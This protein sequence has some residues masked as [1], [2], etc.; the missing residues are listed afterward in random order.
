[1]SDVASPKRSRAWCLTVNNYSEEEF[2]MLLHTECRYVILGREVGSEGTPHIQ[3]YLYFDL[4][5]SFRQ[6][7]LLCPRAHFEIAKGSPDDNYVYCSKDHAYEERGSIPLSPSKKAKKGGDG[8]AERI[9]AAFASAAMGQLDQIPGDLRVRYYRTFKDIKKDHMPSVADADDLTGVWITGPAGCGKSRF[10]RSNYKDPYLK[11]CNKWWDGYQDEENVIIDDFDKTHSVL[12][13]H[14][15]I[16]GDRYSF[17]GETKGGAIQ[18]RPKKIVIT[19]Q[20]KIEDIW[21]DKETQDALNRRFE[22]LDFA[23]D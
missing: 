14:L 11:M 8:N 7:K 18:I 17:I 19:S 16:W 3:G 22:V 10:A 2:Q 20:Y 5:K 21:D 1:M 6:V 9:A 15:K 4:F 12:G 23:M 13:H